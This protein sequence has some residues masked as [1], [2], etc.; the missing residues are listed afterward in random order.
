MQTVGGDGK[1]SLL[2]APSRA[3]ATF[4]LHA[5]F[6]LALRLTL[7]DVNA[8]VVELKCAAAVSTKQLPEEYVNSHFSAIFSGVYEDA[9]IRPALE[10]I[11]FPALERAMDL[12]E[13][14]N[15]TLISNLESGG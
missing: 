9:A 2:L 11:L 13:Q 8:Q 3:W 15:T 6:D 1:E 5:D 10:G 12:G 4:G 14:P 7:L